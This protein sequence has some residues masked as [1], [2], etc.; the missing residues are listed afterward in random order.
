MSFYSLAKK[1]SCLV[2][3]LTFAFVFLLSACLHDKTSENNNEQPDPTDNTSK[4]TDDTSDKQTTDPV[5]DKIDESPAQTHQ[6]VDSR[7]LKNWQHPD[8]LIDRWTTASDTR[9][10]EWVLDSDGSCLFRG[11]FYDLG[12]SN[13]GSC[14]WGVTIID[15][16]EFFV[17]VDASNKWLAYQLTQ[18]SENDFRLLGDDLT[19]TSVLFS[20][21]IAGTPAATFPGRYFLGLWQHRWSYGDK[22]FWYFNPDGT[23]EVATKYLLD[24]NLFLTNGT[25]SLTPTH[26]SF[27][28]EEVSD[29]PYTPQ[30]GSYAINVKSHINFELLNVST[31]SNYWNWERKNQVEQE[32]VLD[33]TGYY[34][35]PG[36]TM[37]ISKQNDNFSVELFYNGKLHTYPGQLD[38]NRLHVVAEEPS[39]LGRNDYVFQ[40][41]L[42]GIRVEDWPP[43]KLFELPT[44][45]YKMSEE[46]LPAPDS[47]IG[48][49]YLWFGITGYTH[50]YT[51]LPDGRFISFRD[52]LPDFENSGIYSVQDNVLSISHYCGIPEK[53]ENQFTIAENQLIMPSLSPDEPLVY[54]YEPYSKLLIDD[55]RSSYDAT[56]DKVRKEYEKL[57][58]T[59][60]INSSFNYSGILRYP[61]SFGDRIFHV[62]PDPNINN[63]FENATVFTK[64]ALYGY[65][66]EITQPNT[67]NCTSYGNP[68]T[69]DEAYFQFLPNGRVVVYSPT[70]WSFAF[71]GGSSTDKPFLW[72]PYRIENEKIII[73]NETSIDIVLN[74]R[75]IIKYGPHCYY[76]E[77]LQVGS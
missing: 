23:L 16:V 42:N 2:S 15:D 18:I 77:H 75:D 22:Q 21:A 29:P 46:Q 14:E 45:F 52:S 20:R 39:L 40:P 24:D 26:L 64:P 63:I 7:F 4:T 51:F 19:V 76:S 70:Q 56:L 71:L 5:N 27:A 62:G 10:I 48:K 61:F 31:D 6:N 67:F 66:S 30:S 35:G 43:G 55:I 65:L 53:L 32:T 13:K 3:V 11:V 17:F 34:N 1:C 74:S 59:G 69:C 73:G 41:I 58:P 68:D 8:W 49:W 57:A 54:M 47:L 60:P 38:G 44:Y 33:Y 37:Y 50:E 28:L 9:E 12:T 72:L 25:W 36:T